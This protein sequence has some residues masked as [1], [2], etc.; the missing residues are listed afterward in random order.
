MESTTEQYRVV[1]VLAHDT[2]RVAASHPLAWDR[3]QAMW[4]QLDNLRLQGHMPH[5]AYYAV[6]STDD[7]AWQGLRVDSRVL[8]AHPDQPMPSKRP[9]PHQAE[10]LGRLVQRSTGGLA[11]QRIAGVLINSNELRWVKATSLGSEMALWHLYRKG[12]ATL[13]VR[14]GPRG[15]EHN[16]YRPTQEG[17]VWVARRQAPRQVAAA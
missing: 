3:A 7:P 16:Y 14:T 5:V 17:I 2:T 15:G 6:R 4:R 9:T 10:V 12:Y 8:Q 11:P 1:A 13:D